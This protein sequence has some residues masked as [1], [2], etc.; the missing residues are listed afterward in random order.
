[1]VEIWL[2]LVGNFWSRC[3]GG[4]RVYTLWIA[5]E[6]PNT[7]LTDKENRAEVSQSSAEVDKVKDALDVLMPAMK[8]RNHAATPVVDRPAD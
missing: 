1:M 4:C 2:P 5:I 6:S 7:V 3:G 8:G